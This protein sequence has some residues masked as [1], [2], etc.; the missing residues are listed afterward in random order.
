MFYIAA[1]NFY[2]SIVI[3]PTGIFVSKTLF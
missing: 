3:L 1:F 2:H